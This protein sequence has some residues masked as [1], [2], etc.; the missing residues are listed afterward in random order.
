MKRLPW[1]DIRLDHYGKATR[2]HRI[3][4]RRLRTTAFRHLDCPG[5]RQAIQAVR[6]RRDLTSGKLSI[7]RLYV[8]T[9]LPAGAASGA[10]PAGW[11]RVH[12]KIESQLH[13]VRDTTFTEDASRIRSGGLRCVMATLRNLAISAFRQDGRTNI[14]AACRHTARDPR[15][16]LTALGIT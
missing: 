3:E 15:R 8:V 12:W 11:I 10:E 9:S 14:A 16:P 5:A 4:I 7:Q 1:T 6:W 13:H 2:H